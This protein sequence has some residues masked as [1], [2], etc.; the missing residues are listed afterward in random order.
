VVPHTHSGRRSLASLLRA[1]PRKIGKYKPLFGAAFGDY[2]GNFSHWAWGDIDTLVGDMSLVGGD[3]LARFD[4]ISFNTGSGLLYLQGQLTILA[5]KPNV[6]WAW[7]EAPG[8]PSLARLEPVFA[9]EETEFTDWVLHQSDLNVKLEPL[10]LSGLKG[11][12]WKPGDG[13]VVVWDRG[14]LL[15]HLGTQPNEVEQRPEG[16][17]LAPLLY[18]GTWTNQPQRPG[19]WVLERFGSD[20]S[21]AWQPSQ[22]PAH[23]YNPSTQEYLV[24]H[25]NYVHEENVPSALEAKTPLQMDD[26]IRAACIQWQYLPFDFIPHPIDRPIASPQ[27]QARLEPTYLGY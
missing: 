8:A 12:K 4:I 13:H 10:Q 14:R 1:T 6:V 3:D 2:I 19:P 24:F 27:A 22:R 20:R 7:K 11:K 15:L 25:Y 23:G 26:L 5:N 9:W 17:E 18:Q 21:C 16:K